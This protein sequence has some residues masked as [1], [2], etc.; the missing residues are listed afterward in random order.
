MTLHEKK[1]SVENFVKQYE[2]PRR[3]VLFSKN[4]TLGWEAMKKWNW[5]FLST[6]YRIAENGGIHAGGFT[7][8]MQ[9]YITN[10]SMNITKRM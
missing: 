1:L 6:K 3:P 2:E 8:D 4:I 10:E 9:D 7:F 5:E